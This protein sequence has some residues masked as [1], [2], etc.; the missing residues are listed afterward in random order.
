MYILRLDYFK[1]Q[2]LRLDITQIPY[3]GLKFTLLSLTFFIPDT[4]TL[5]T[6]LETS[7]FSYPISDNGA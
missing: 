6:H 2:Y 1:Q 5:S 7:P 4:M 3:I